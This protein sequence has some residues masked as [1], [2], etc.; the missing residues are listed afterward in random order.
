[1]ADGNKTEQASPRKRQKAREKGQIA[2][3]RDLISSLAVGTMVL[4]SATQLPAFAAQWRALLSRGLDAAASGELQP[5]PLLADAGSTLVRAVTVIVGLSWMAAV[6]GACAQGGLVFAPASLQPNLSRLSPA[7]RLEQLFSLPSVGRLLKS[8]LPGAVIVYVLVTILTREWNTLL[9]LPH[10][11]VNGLV[12]YCLTHMLEI[13]WKSALVL[14]VWSGA[15]FMIEKHK[16]SSDL[17]M[18]K[19]DQRD[20][21]KETEGHPAVKARIRRLRRQA[22]RRRMLEE[23]KKASVVITN[24][25]EFAVALEYRPDMAAPTVVAKGRN[26]FAQQIKQ[27]ARWYGI[28]LVENPPLAHA[29]YRTL[30]VGQS[31][32]PKLYAVVAAI[33]AAIF[34][35][36]QR[37]AAGAGKGRQ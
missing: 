11:G 30:E 8:L 6:L 10:L 25:N 13:A 1:M 36:E 37:A 15:D 17:R 2:V 28:T 7:K 3:S 29:L 9:A 34:R 31:I 22:R 23:V 32:P 33:L 20:E 27:M 24:P 21:Y 14:L 26:L 4:M 35:A 18:S 12:A 19:Q 5:Q 16:L